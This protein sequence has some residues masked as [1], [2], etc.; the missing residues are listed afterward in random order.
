MNVAVVGTGYVGLVVGAGLAEMG[1]SVICADVDRGKIVP[2]SPRGTS[3]GESWREGDQKNAPPLASPGV[4]GSSSVRT[5]L[6][7]PL[8]TSGEREMP[9]DAWC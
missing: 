9:G 4:H 1:N 2:L 3:V 8:P 7:R 6:P 5:P